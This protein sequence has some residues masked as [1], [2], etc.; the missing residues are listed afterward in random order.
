MNA[1]ASG[2]F[3]A[4][5]SQKFDLSNFYKDVTR[6]GKNSWIWDSWEITNIQTE[7]IDFLPDEFKVCTISMVKGQENYLNGFIIGDD[8][9]EVIDSINIGDVISFNAIPLYSTVVSLNDDTWH[10]DGCIIAKIIPEAPSPKEEAASEVWSDEEYV[11]TIDNVNARYADNPDR[12]YRQLPEGTNIGH[13]KPVS[14]LNGEFVF[15]TMD[16]E[17]LLIMKQYIKLA[18]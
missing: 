14:D 15:F 6:Y 12:V 1:N 2:L 8:F 18:D 3:L 17:D 10:D 13:I 4:N 11:V 7:L 5:N 16:G 9:S